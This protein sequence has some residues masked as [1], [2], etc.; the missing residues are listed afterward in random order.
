LVKSTQGGLRQQ[1]ANGLENRD[2][3]NA[4]INVIFHPSQYPH[5]VQQELKRCL[6]ERALNHK[7]H[8]E[9]YKQTQKWL[10]LHEAY[11][12][13]RTDPDCAS[14]YDA[15]FEATALA[16]GTKSIHLI[17]LGCGG[18]QKDARLLEIIAAPNKALRYTPVDV[19]APMALV[20][21]LATESV[22]GRSLPIVCDL[23]LATGLSN[24][25]DQQT[26]RNA[27]R[28]VTFFG[29]I[30][31]FYAATILPRLSELVRANDLLLFSANL[32]PGPD[33]RRGVERV[34]PLYDNEL[35]C[36]W[37]LTF[38]GDLGIERSDGELQWSI[39]GDKFLRLQASFVFNRNRTITIGEDEF[40]F[41]AGE[42]LRLFFSYRYTP[43]LT[44]ELL[45][46][47]GF[48]IE[49]NWI[50]K[51]GEEGVFLCLRTGHSD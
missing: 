6:R 4:A 22:A 43:D 20:A 39:E 28:L 3:M 9:S 23:E 44:S 35:T 10:V 12:P 49:Q 21:C 33:Y 15:A 5:A 13:A 37:L 24:L 45:R 1:Q 30:P 41:L 14:I 17:G 7:F 38:L 18:G 16:C 31:N 26:L 47:H 46:S 2:E 50:T 27:A 32:A 29:M 51:S 42:R 25:I 19:S 11:S 34:R 48:A 40:H 8:Y 36:D